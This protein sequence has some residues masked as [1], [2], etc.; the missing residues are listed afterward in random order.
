MLVL[1]KPYFYDQYLKEIA[2]TWVKGNDD[3]ISYA[4]RVS[5]NAIILLKPHVL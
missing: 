5:V 4:V 1:W 3:M 2:W